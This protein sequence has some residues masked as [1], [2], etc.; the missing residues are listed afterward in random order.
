MRI[1]RSDLQQAL[2]TAIEKAGIKVVYD[3][4]LVSVEDDSSK[5]KI[6]AVF[7]NGSSV[8]GDFIIGCDGVRSAVRTAYVE[9][10]RIALYSGAAGAYSI[11]DKGALTVPVHFQDSGL[12]LSRHG[13]VLTSFVDPERTKIYIAAVMQVEEQESK[14]EWRA[15]GSDHDAIVKEIHRRYDDSAIPCLPQMVNQLKDLFLFPVF[16]LGPGGKWTRGRAV[17]LGDAAH[18]VSGDGPMAIFDRG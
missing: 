15:R 6:T 16:Q 18:A 11:V 13:T 8:S 4:R 14:M 12:N 2:L 10:G 5:D 1:L 9:P 7:A 17:L 3:S